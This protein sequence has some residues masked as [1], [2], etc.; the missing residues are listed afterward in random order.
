MGAVVLTLGA[1]AVA[2]TPK[3]ALIG[4]SV[5]RWEDLKPHATDV[6]TYAQR[7]QGPTLTPD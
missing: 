4:P 1:V 6:G 5:W 2:Q 7:P 3:P